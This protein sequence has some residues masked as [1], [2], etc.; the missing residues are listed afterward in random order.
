MTHTIVHASPR[1]PMWVFEENY[2]LLQQLLPEMEAG[3][4]RYVLMPEDGSQQA[5]ELLIL[6][7]CAYTTIVE[8]NKPFFIDGVW[9]PDLRMQLRTYHDAQVVEVAAYQGCHRIPA[10]YQVDPGGRYLRDEKRQINLLL[11]EL[12]LYCQRNGYHEQR[13]PDCSS[14]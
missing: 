12:L 7:R 5:L 13:Q 11:H 14:I 2:R 6:E 8:L 1:S 10:R 3:G 9:M 4:D